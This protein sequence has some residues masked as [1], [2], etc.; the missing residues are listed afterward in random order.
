MLGFNG[1]KTEEEE[2]KEQI[3]IYLNGINLEM[4]EEKTV[5]THASTQ[6]ARFLGYILFK[7]EWRTPS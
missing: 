7:Q 3:G 6:K 5:I 1:Y 2:S 4:S